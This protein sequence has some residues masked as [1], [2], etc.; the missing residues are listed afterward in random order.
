MIENE[1]EKVAECLKFGRKLAGLTQSDVAE[2]LGVTYQAISNYER[3][4]NRIDQDTLLKLCSLYGIPPIELMEDIDYALIAKKLKAARNTK[5]IT[6]DQAATAL[7][8]SIKDFRSYE[9]GHTEI[10]ISA[11]L[12]LCK[13]YGIDVSS[14]LKYKN[15][16]FYSHESIVIGADKKTFN[17]LSDSL[18]QIA[19]EIKSLFDDRTD[20]ERNYIGISIKIDITEDFVEEAKLKMQ[21]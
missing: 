10:P 3:G 11:I 6:Q 9:S 7:G 15:L 4:I 5:K 2:K 12:K 18:T 1:R 13:L 20:D 21:K 8:I 16:L 19:L 17:D 14:L